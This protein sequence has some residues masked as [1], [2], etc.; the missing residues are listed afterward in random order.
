MENFSG[1]YRRG[2]TSRRSGSAAA[3]RKNSA[4]NPTMASAANPARI[5]PQPKDDP[6]QD[7]DAGA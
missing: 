4:V 2:A 5:S 7:A 6:A 3:L 1:G